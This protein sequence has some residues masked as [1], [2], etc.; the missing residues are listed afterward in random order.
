VLGTAA[1]GVIYVVSRI[2]A[3]MPDGRNIPGLLYVAALVLALFMLPT[4]A[5]IPIPL[6]LSGR[7]QLARTG[8]KQSRWRTVWTVAGSLPIAVEAVFLFRLTRFS[9]LRM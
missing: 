8:I 6:L 4:C 1:C 5:M 2:P 9:G 3:P 7:R